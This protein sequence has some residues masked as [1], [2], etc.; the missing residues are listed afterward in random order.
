MCILS[1]VEWEK[2]GID[3]G[4]V[5]VELVKEGP[6]AQAGLAVGDV[7]LMLDQQIVENLSGF[8][9]ILESLAAGRAVSV[10]IQRGE[11]RMFYAL[12]IPKP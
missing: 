6:A 4:G 8:N 10:L 9:R 11:G 3:R 7:I 5:L 2:L 1:H 12:R